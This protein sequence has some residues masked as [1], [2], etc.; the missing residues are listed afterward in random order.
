MRISLRA[1]PWA[2]AVLAS[3]SAA[4][5]GLAVAFPDGTQRMGLT[6]SSGG[7]QESSQRN[8]FASNL[9]SSGHTRV[10]VSLDRSVLSP[11]DD[12]FI[13]A[14][15]RPK[16]KVCTAR[17]GPAV[18]V[19]RKLAAKR[20]GAGGVSW[21]PIIPYA[22]RAGAWRVRVSCV[23]GGVG[24]AHF[25]VVPSPP[26]SS[27]PPPP[28]VSAV[29]PGSYSGATVHGNS[30]FFD[31]LSNRTVNGWRV[32]DIRDQCVPG[33]YIY[34]GLDLR[35]YAMAIDDQGRFAV[36]WNYTTTLRSDNGDT[37]PATG[38]DRIA[39]YIQGS[40]AAGTVLEEI[41]FDRDGR[42]FQCS[43]NEESWTAN[44]LP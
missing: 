12:V 17:I 31:V 5:V 3:L 7:L 4:S 23:G 41:E 35:T 22:A 15:V 13:S 40:I 32:N 18:G 43:N 29:D 25:R 42:H 2:V 44:R 37:L 36:D 30:V 27:S 20:A 38:H 16:G 33:G 34:G 14:S 6:F 19:G 39:G 28:S 1:A 9:S 24:S 11:G 10:S 8:P 21:D 26:T